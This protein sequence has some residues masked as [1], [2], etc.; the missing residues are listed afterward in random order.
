MVL[1]PLDLSSLY[2]SRMSIS[3]K[4]NFSIDQIWLPS[5]WRLTKMAGSLTNAFL[6]EMNDDI[7]SNECSLS[8]FATNYY[9]SPTREKC[10]RPI[11][12]LP[13]LQGHTPKA[14]YYFTFWNS[15]ISVFMKFLWDQPVLSYSTHGSQKSRRNQKNRFGLNLEILLINRS[16]WNFTW[17]LQFAWI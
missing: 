6:C 9:Y 11:C 4:S 10:S 7:S 16:L 13:G 15:T 14:P 3:F 2:S 1:S 8:I 5:R 12:S 17:S